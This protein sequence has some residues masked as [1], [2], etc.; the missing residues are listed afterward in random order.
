MR[1][2][3]LTKRQE[4]NL[5]WSQLDEEYQRFRQQWQDLGDYILPDRTRFFLTDGDTG[6]PNRKKIIDT[7]GTLA[8]RTL[9]SGMMS[10][11]TSPARPWFSLTTPDPDLADSPAVK[12]WLHTV[13]ERMYTIFQRSNFYNVMPTLYGDLGTFGTG[14]VFMEEDFETVVRYHSLPIGSYRLALDHRGKVGVFAREFRMTVRQLVQKFGSVDE[15]TGRP[16]WSNF[17]IRV[18]NLWDQAKYQTKIDVRHIIYPNPEYDPKKLHSKYKRFYSCYFEKAGT[19]ENTYLRESGYERFPVL[20]PRWKVT[21]EDAYGSECPGMLTLPD[22]K[23]LQLGEKRGLEAIEKMVKP[24]V[25]A[26]TSLRKSGV[27]MLPG[28]V[29]WANE[30]EGSKGVRSAYDVRF[31][32]TH[33]EQKQERVRVR[34]NSGYFV[35]VMIPIM[36]VEKGDMTATEVAERKE[37]KLVVIGPV[38]QRVEEDCLDPNIDNTFDFMLRQSDPKLQDPRS[39]IPPPPEELKGVALQIKYD[40]IL[41]Q[42]LKVAG[43]A[44]LERFGNFAGMLVKVTGSPTVLDKVNLNKY[45]DV[46]GDALSVPPG[47]IRTDEEAASL[48]A[49]R[50]KAQAAQQAADQVEQG[51][52]AVKNLSQTDMSNDNAL[53]RLVDQSRA[54]QVVPQ[55]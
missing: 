22:I 5:L 36:S 48:G 41:H 4:L 31:D 16:D 53:T 2:V 38:L 34:I 24:P 25:I 45:I 37:E 13:T 20:A 44:G 9:E 39:L 43:V 40:S 21:G 32:L 55:Q 26:P 23:Q 35:D 18:K 51:T 49:Q 46:Y 28:G 15:K 29:T 3:D 10:G 6:P 52:N 14:A 33:L 17:S 11:I 50:Q 19:D 8:A 54:G 7:T 27:N 42:A 12:Q 30:R 1:T 47:V